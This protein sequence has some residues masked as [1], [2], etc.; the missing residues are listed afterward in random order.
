MDLL[1]RLRPRWRHPDAEIR[2]AAVREM[3]T[4]DQEHL[5]A[6]A[7][8]DPDPHVR[9]VAI[10]KVQSPELLQTI[11][12]DDVDPALRELAAERE[13]EV[14]VAIACSSAPLAEGEAALSRL[15][16]ERSLATVAIGGA[17]E[18]I[19]HAALARIRSERTLR[20]VVRDASDAAL[21]RAALDRL[22]DPAALRS[23]AVSDCPPELALRAVERIDDPEVLRA[24]AENHAAAKDA[25][26]RAREKVGESPSIAFKDA[27]AREHALCMAAEALSNERDVMLAATRLREVEREWQELTR[28]APPRDDTAARFAAACEAILEAAA[29][30][31]RRE[32]EVESAQTAVRTNL[33][34]RSALCERVEGLEGPDALRAL[35]D[36]RAEWERLPP[37]SDDGLTRRFAQACE[38]CELRRQRWLADEGQRAELVALVEEAEALAASTP[39]PAAK[40]WRALEARWRALARGDDV[41]ERR[42]ATAKAELERRRQ[43]G[44]QRQTELRQKNLARLESLC[45][46]VQEL[47]KAETSS[48]R[49]VRREL[50]AVDAALQDLG[51]LPPSERREAW[52]ERLAAAH[53]DLM[54]RLGQ[55]EETE[56]WRRWA[57]TGAQEEI[58]Q[59]VE[60]LLASNDLLEGTRQLGRLQEE[61]AQVASASPD[62]SQA[63][64]DRFRTARNELRKH[65]DV[66]LA[67]NLEK[68][69]ALCAQVAEV[70]D[71]TAWNETAG[72]IRRVQAEW[73]SLGP[74]P[75]KHVRALWKQFREPCDR[76]FA[77]RNE[78]WERV[79]SERRENAKQK[80]ALCEQ[81]EALAD[82][83]DWESTTTAMKRLQAEWKRGGPLPRAEAERLWQRFRGACDRFF[84]RRGRRE[85]IQREERVRR[86]GALCDQLESLGASLDAA[87]APS[88]ESVGKKV[89]ESWAEWRRQELG[90]GDDARALGERLIQAVQRIAALRPESLKGTRLEPA[91]TRKRREKLCLRLEEIVAS[92]NAEPR[93]MSLQ[94]MAL[95]LRER[96]ATNTIAGGAGGSAAGRQQVEQEVARIT[97]SWTQLGPALDEEARGLEARF[98]R[99]QA[100]MKG[101]A[102]VR[103]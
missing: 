90:T 38:A 63:L 29:S 2:V 53:D 45:T 13:R 68:K 5:E 97:A 96:L 70:G 11:A 46:R 31:A 20:D 89:E 22:A 91:A 32:A 21:R 86:A 25:R 36:A 74:V 4:G 92:A 103:A 61:W 71:S 51:P 41:L 87:D 93:K 62:K 19:R 37:L 39:V 67:E 60:G 83:T 84:E 72:L 23:I 8:E 100:G 27:R 6:I 85:E 99:A 3:D 15:T 66:Y 28:H 42:F 43:E 24:I 69:R 75:A 82:S 94:E 95:A 50:R 47:V 78:H 77:Q 59:R 48:P 26:R 14:L 57:N 102:G 44:E 9:R 49:A 35:A 80:T 54:R 79:G 7:R 58:I 64:W 1:Q 101:K 40:R 65:C 73:K 30:V 16:D 12:A 10:K 56:E 17:H 88:D 98:E 52:T 81:A 33:A 34:A 18:S 76:F 55:E